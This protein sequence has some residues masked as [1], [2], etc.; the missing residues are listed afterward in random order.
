MLAPSPAVQALMFRSPVL[1]R[2]Q[3]VAGGSLALQ[4]GYKPRLCPYRVY[5][6][7]I[8][9][10]GPPRVVVALAEVGVEEDQWAVAQRRYLLEVDWG[11]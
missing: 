9:S 8:E 1:A 5:Q 7:G 11:G 2:G 6:D 3:S 10:A 4:I